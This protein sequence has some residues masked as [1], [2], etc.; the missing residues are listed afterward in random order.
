M[1]YLRITFLLIPFL[2]LACTGQRTENCVTYD[3]GF[4]VCQDTI[5]VNE[6]GAM[7]KVL[8]YHK[9]FYVL[10]EKETS[11]FRR[12][13]FP[14]IPY[15]RWIQVFSNGKKE[16]TINLPKEKNVFSVDFFVRNDSI[17][18]AV[19]SDE[20]YYLETQNFKWKG[21]EKVNNDLIFEDEKFYVY[22]LDRGE[23]GGVTWF[24]DKKTGIEYALSLEP[25]LIN[26][27]DTTYYL[28]RDY[29]ILK[30]EN[31]LKLNEVI[32]TVE[33]YDWDREPIGFD[34]VY[35][36][37]NYDYFAC[38]KITRKDYPRF[39]NSFVFQNEL[40]HIFT[41][42]KETY[43]VQVE[44]NT[45]KPIQKIGNQLFGSYRNNEQWIG[46]IEI[47]DNKISVQYFY[48]NANLKH[49]SNNDLCAD[50]IFVSRFNFILS[51]F[52]NLRLKD[53]DVIDQDYWTKTVFSN[54]SE[55]I[56]GTYFMAEDTLILNRI[57]YH[58]EKNVVKN[59]FFE[60]EDTYCPRCDLKKV[61]R[62]IFATKLN[63][64]ET[65]LNQKLGNPVSYN[66]EEYLL[67][68][69]W[70]T[71]NGLTVG[72]MSRKNF[73]SIRLNISKDKE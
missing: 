13:F 69:T 70:K 60:W 52:E 34:T 66:D 62:E 17:I 30:I 3:N 45:I 68:I 67:S 29:K 44:N 49:K 25:S 64:L 19:C 50:S 24:K 36:D 1:K 46:L 38:G 58:L 35:Y 63:F 12:F 42:Y 27:I 15:E 6:K 11:P 5:F 43:I 22:S 14:H 57:E 31:P 56:G 37:S 18:L 61:S 55:E 2:F 23:F 71:S 59:V 21:I 65:F 10:F 53:V 7:T 26:K 4:T 72:L 32:K 51:E 39:L 41:K 33:P 8:S 73:N 40:F 20:H 47:I 48:N 9:K 54:A 28:T 16:K